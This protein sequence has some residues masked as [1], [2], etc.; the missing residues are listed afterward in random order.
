M[1]QTLKTIIYEWKT[2]K[3]PQIIEREINLES[4]LTLKPRK[5]ITV[6]GFRRVGKTYLIFQLIE[7]LLQKNS[8]EN[9]FYINFEDE[10]IPKKT[11]FLTNLLPTVKQVFKKLPKYLFLDEI[12]E[13]PNWSQWVRRIYDQEEMR[14]F[15]TGSSSKMSSR[16]IPTELRGRC[17]EKKIFPLSFND[18]L[19]FKKVKIDFGAVSYSGDEKAKLMNLL[20]EYVLYGGM[21]EV[22]LI[23]EGRKKELL[24]EYYQTVVRKDIIQRFNLKN[25]EG[26]KA[27]LRLILNSTS[28]SATKLYHTLKSLN[29]RIGKTTLL[30]Y[31]SDIENSYF[32]ESL[33]IFSYKIKDQLQ[34]PRKIYIVDNGF[35]TALSSSFSND[36]GR[37]Y[38]NLVFQKLRR[39][40]E[41]E[42]FYWKD[43][44]NREVDFVVR[45]LSK[46]QK[47]IQVCYDLGNFETK[48]REIKSLISANKKFGSQDIERVIINQDLEKIEEIQGVKIRYIPL[49]KMDT[50]LFR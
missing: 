18:F 42:I 5:I 8:R 6:T 24:Q 12:Q 29:Y 45:K 30:E 32:L 14:I 11:E 10:R 27:L 49:W 7:K 44:N 37:L 46:V 39:N 25:E 21:P 22:V 1:E 17:L 50:D 36:F 3:L 34:Y 13:M 41:N 2:R 23:E 26:L 48:E 4:Y 38:E 9:I 40:P 47:L 35:I 20:N 33:P 43:R 28:Y 31:L 16:E 19:K 15:I